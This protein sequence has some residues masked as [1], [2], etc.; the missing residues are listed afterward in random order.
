[1][2]RLVL[3]VLLI[4]TALATCAACYVVTVARLWRAEGWRPALLGAVFFPYAYAWCWRHCR[5]SMRVWTSA[6][7]LLVALVAL[8]ET[9]MG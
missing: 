1:M 4:L 9:Q 2:G 3:I 6:F 5:T 7:A 8:L